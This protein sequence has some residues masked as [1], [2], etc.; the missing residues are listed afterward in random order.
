VL[1]Q[2]S[3]LNTALLGQFISALEGGQVK[4]RS[5]RD[6]ATRSRSFNANVRVAGAEG[7]S[8]SEEESQ[9]EL[10]D[11]AFAQFDRLLTAAEADPD[12][13]DWIEVTQPDLEL[14]NARR[15]TMLSWDCEV[16]IPEVVQAFGANSEA[17]DLLRTMTN[18]MPAAETFGLD[19]AGLPD[20]NAL[21]SMSGLMDAMQIDP[22]IVGDRE[23][24]TWK[25]FA[26]VDPSYELEPLDGPLQIVGKVRRVIA[27]GNWHPLLSLPGSNIGSREQRRAQARQTPPEDQ[28][29]NY[30]AGPAIELD[31]LAAFA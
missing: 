31:L 25:V 15:G 17:R 27:E 29:Q 23:D 19:T 13:L 2:F 6:V 20:A 9:R 7:G 4:T 3:Y 22:T 12:A 1:R 28:Q 5:F 10:L 18:L 26:K 8:E 30:I 14:R 11:T 21:R 16:F 24:T